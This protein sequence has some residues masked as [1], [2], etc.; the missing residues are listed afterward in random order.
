[1]RQFSKSPDPGAEK[2]RKSAHKKSKIKAR[3][4]DAKSRTH[5]RREYHTHVYGDAF[6]TAAHAAHTSQHD[7]AGLILAR[8]IHL[9][10]ALVE[11]GL[12][13][14]FG[15]DAQ[16]GSSY[17][18]GHQNAGAQSA[19]G[20][21]AAGA[22]QQPSGV[23]WQQGTYRAPEPPG[24]YYPS[25][26]QQSS[27]CITV[28][29]GKKCRSRWGN[30]SLLAEIQRTAAYQGLAVEIA[31]CDCMDFCDEAPLVTVTSGR[32]EEYF[33]GVGLQDVPNIIAMATGG[34][35]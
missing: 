18:A 35:V 28:C 32:A 10:G 3:K 11:W 30:G 22:Y 19:R 6:G 21:G 29:T 17:S 9:L 13:R 34:R 12:S 8:G 25:T 33:S 1:M 27:S 31:S 26:P 15:A 7:A 23:G 20:W 2:K 16:A 24:A 4:H 5:S 14:R